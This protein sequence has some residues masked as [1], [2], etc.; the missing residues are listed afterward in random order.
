MMGAGNCLEIR[1][2]HYAYGKRPEVLRG[3]DLTVPRGSIVALLGLNGAGKTTLIRSAVGL[4]RPVAGGIE[5]LDRPLAGCA[6]PPELLA[7]VGYVPER[8]TLYERMTAKAVL[9]LVRDV[10]PR[11][12]A[13]TVR[14]Y[15]EVF[16][17]PLERRCKDL[18]AGTKAQLALT[19]AMAGQPE[20]LI[21]DEP[22]LGLDPLH[23]H[24]YL[25]L[26][27]AEAMS[28]DLAILM[29]SHDLH[30]IERMADQVAILHEGRIVVQEPLDGIKERVR[31]IRV[32][33]ADSGSGLAAALAAL[34]GVSKVTAEPG[35]YL[36]TTQAAPAEVASRAAAMPG[37][38]G[39][40][41]LGLSLEEIFLSYCEL[42]PASG[43]YSTTF[44][45]GR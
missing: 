32:G 35:G 13:Q 8:P 20:L 16:H 41:V 19:L 34:P 44:G 43:E 33:A 9:D 37:V 5:L 31:R 40:Q 17:I 2:L 29:S 23:R 18:S 39:V 26:L 38:N 36:L 22:T 27:L 4:I 25:Q 12:H 6:A 10:H 21:L 14:R 11:W 7:R 30:Q 24:Q 28:R 1:D 45:M 3:A 15:L 42:T